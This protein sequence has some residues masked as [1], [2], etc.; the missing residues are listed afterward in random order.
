MSIRVL[1]R[2]AVRPTEDPER[3]ER[4]VLNLFPGADLARGALE[5][6]GE[7]RDLARLASLVS[8]HRIPDTARGVMVRGIDAA[9]ATRSRFLLGKQAAFVGKPNFGPQASPLGE[10]EVTL[11]AES[12]QA[13]ERAIYACA[14]DTTVPDDLA[15]VPR[16]ER[17][18]A[19]VERVAAHQAAIA[20][21]RDE[22]ERASLQEKESAPKKRR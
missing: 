12:P 19:D 21:K 15:T 11:A 3:V 22:V 18:P 1:V 20:A 13:L 9:D 7:A 8:E 6:T 16:S 2:A 4:A 14:P 10:I 17:T 5:I